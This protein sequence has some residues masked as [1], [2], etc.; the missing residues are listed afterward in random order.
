[1][2]SAGILMPVFSLP[3]SYGIG[4][5]SAEAYRFVDFLE[6]AG[7]SYW[8]ILPLG[9]TSY[10]DSP[11]QSFSTFAGNPY[12][13]DP[14]TLKNEGL[15][16]EADLH[17]FPGGNEDRID[18]GKQYENR[19]TLLRRAFGRFDTDQEGYRAFKERERDWLF[20]YALF[21]ALKDAHDGRSFTEWEDDYRKR[22]ETALASFLEDRGED[23]EFYIFIQYEF[24]TQWKRLKEYANNHGIEIIGDIP[25]YVAADSSDVWTGPELFQMDEDQKPTAV[26]G[27]PPDGFSAD[28]QLWGNPLYRWDYHES[29]GY[30]WWIRR[31]KKCQELYD[32]VR[33]DHFRGFDEYYSI[34]AGNTTAKGGHWEKGPGIGLFNK[35]RQELGDVRIIAED[36]GFITDSV[37]ALVKECGFPNM[38]VLEFGFDSRDSSGVINKENQYLPFNYHRNSVVYTGTHDNE[39]LRG[40]LDSITPL[41][42]Q[43]LKDYLGLPDSATKPSVVKGMIRLA[44]GSVS[45]MAV[46]P[47]W[48]YLRLDNRARINTPSTL[49]D[50]WRWRVR[51]KVLSQ[52]KAEE[53]RK[54]TEVYGR[55]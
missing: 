52:E 43:S 38:K 15:L 49:G 53:I 8:Q 11:Y 32:I 22:D 25:I 21:M 28:G 5:F 55:L 3:G 30:E 19:F 33:I 10:G 24:F 1:M 46:I 20:D 31:I 9:P 40:W 7:Q 51:K 39:T 34:P 4:C 54:L 37:R 47:L 18:Y 17:D 45:D 35:I 41:E 26:S 36:L 6:Q 13:V 2:R 29:T 23:V 50:N 12:F 27:C 16:T 42:L 48:D 14:D 44:L